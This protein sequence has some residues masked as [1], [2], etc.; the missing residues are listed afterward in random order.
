MVERAW[1]CGCGEGERGRERRRKGR[2][3][4]MPGEREG[5]RRGVGR[6][7]RSVAVEGEWSVPGGVGDVERA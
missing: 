7:G 4:R 5:G 2:E 6:S 3:E 1:A